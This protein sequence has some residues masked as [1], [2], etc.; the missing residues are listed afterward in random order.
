MGAAVLPS[1]EKL[2]WKD[3]KLPQDRTDA[4]RSSLPTFLSVLSDWMSQVNEA[5][6]A[7]AAVELAK[8]QERDALHPSPAREKSPCRNF[9]W[10]TFSSC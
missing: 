3:H 5:P 7:E 10:K 8:R 4:Q 9:F 1:Q 6:L 2:V